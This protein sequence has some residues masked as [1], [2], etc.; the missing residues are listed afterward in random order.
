MLD[1]Y[2]AER[3]GTRCKDQYSNDRVTLRIEVR[4]LIA[5]SRGFF[6]SFSFTLYS[7]FL[8]LLLLFFFTLSISPPP[9][10]SP[11]LSRFDLDR[12]FADH[13]RTYATE[14]KN[15]LADRVIKMFLSDLSL[16]GFPLLTKKR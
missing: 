4:I 13:N 8:F 12:G 1:R 14:K 16:F 11:S 5:A 2:R 15:P 3:S 6:F 10:P 7:F 9:S